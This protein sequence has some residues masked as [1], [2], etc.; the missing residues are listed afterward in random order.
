MA[1]ERQTL[2]HVANQVRMSMSRATVREFDDE[3]LMQQC[4]QADVYHSE[5]PSDFERW[6]MVGVTSTP[7]KQDQDQQ[8]QQSKQSSDTSA[9]SADQGD[10]NHDQPKGNAAEAV[11]MY[12]GGSRSHPIAMVDDR[13][14]R[15]YKVPEGATALYAASGS[16]QM[17]Y[18]NDDGSFIVVT[19]N[20]KYD[21]SGGGGG[22]GAGGGGAGAGASIA[23]RDLSI[24][25]RATGASGGQQQKERYASIRHVNKKPQDRKVGS[26]DQSG[27]SSSGSSSSSSSSQPYQHE[28]EQVNTEIRCTSSRIEFRVGGSVVGYYDKQGTKWSF[29]GEMHLGTDSASH[30]VYGVNG[31][32]GMTTETSGSGAVLVNAPKPGPPTSEDLEPLTVMDRI[33]ELERRIAALEA[34]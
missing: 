31:S 16:G 10:W 2:S 24:S 20:P 12:L 22:A 33:A 1:N 34:K 7:L 25:A 29:T 13:R 28:G 9:G 5:T 15:P 14:V 18:H 21:N 11:M 30:P 8:Q 32:V 23:K 6:Q 26:S 4:K 17:F 27:G 3:H 19:N